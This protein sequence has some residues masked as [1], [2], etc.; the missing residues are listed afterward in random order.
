MLK[1]VSLALVLFISVGYSAVN[2][3]YPMRKNYGNETIN[4]T[5]SRASAELKGIFENFVKNFYEEGN[6]NG[7][8]KDCARIKFDEPENTVSEGIG[9]GMIMM[10]YFSDKT[11][12]YEEEFKK[13][14]AYYKKYSVGGVMDW[15]IQ[16]FTNNRPG[17][18]SASDAEFDVALALVMAH[19]QFASGNT[20]DYLTAATA[21][22][23]DTWSKDMN[24]SDGSHRLGSNWDPYKNPSYISPAAFEIFKG[25]GNSTNWTNAISKNYAILTGNQNSSTGLPSGWANN[26]SPYGPVSCTNGCSSEGQT[27]YDQDAVR[28]PWRWAWANA[29]FGNLTAHSSAKTLLNKLGSWVNGKEPGD[30]KGPIS[31]T[32]T[33]GTD[34]SSGYIGSLMCALTGNSTYQSKLNSYWSTLSGNASESYY[35]QALQVLFGLLV[36]GNMPNL[37]A[38]AGSGCG[39]DMGGGAYQ[40]G[41]TSID[42]FDRGDEEDN[43]DRGY[44]RTWEPWIAYTDID[45]GKPDPACTADPDNRGGSSTISNVKFTSKDENNNCEEVTSYTVVI[46]EGN[47]WAARIPSYELIKGGNKYSP[48]VALGLL[49]KNNGTD[50]NF[51][52][53]TGFSYE[54]KGQSHNFKAQ[55][56]EIPD[57]EGSDHF[58][59]ISTVATGWTEVEVSFSDLAQPTWAT[60]KHTFDPAKVEGFIWEL[61][62]GD[63]PASNPPPCTA[64]GVSACTGSLAIRNF[65]CLGEMPLSATRGASKCNAGG[66]GNSSSSNR[67]S[68]SAHSSSSGGSSSSGDNSP[69]LL[70]QIV[71]T[72][73][74]IPM[75][76]AVNLQVKDNATIQI[77]DL[78]GNAVRT[79]NFSPGNYIVQLSDLPHGLYIVKASNNSWRRIVKA[80]VN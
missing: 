30:I 71:H 52:N 66:G 2:Y 48:Y 36:T 38:C 55:S 58:T 27:L 80:T 75:Q 23:N 1:K 25:V 22:I 73:A 11:K 37:K 69:I 4:A 9:Y 3:P 31:L 78:K 68:S 41:K 46:K 53:C 28:A 5:S 14:W 74:L 40:G 12:S 59:K 15:K 19:Y 72:N 44:A 54:Y 32:G 39:T 63:P 24:S 21:L 10:V 76:N 64:G 26:N 79:L 13:L 17:T 43:D 47:E 49:A 56:K 62:G 34:A 20:S 8:A 16:G 67:S 50:Y 65:K 7:G 60:T 29:W 51:S 35:N 77:F 42:K 57:C 61:K 18:G 33:M 45:N 6:C 70:P